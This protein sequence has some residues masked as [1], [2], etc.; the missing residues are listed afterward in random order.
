MAWDNPLEHLTLAAIAFPLT[1]RCIL[2][3][4]GA[5]ALTRDE[6][7]AIEAFEPFADQAAFLQLPPDSRNS[8]DTWWARIFTRAQ[9]RL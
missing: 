2:Q 6:L 7:A 9:S 3:R 5:Y 1:V 8:L 4:A